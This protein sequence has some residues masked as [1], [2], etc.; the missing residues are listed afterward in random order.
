M[1][2]ELRKLDRVIDAIEARIE[3]SVAAKQER[4]AKKVEKRTS[5]GNTGRLTLLK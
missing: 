4:S 1:K 2:T 3:G 5:K